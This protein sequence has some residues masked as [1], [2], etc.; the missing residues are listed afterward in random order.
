MEGSSTTFILVGV[1][2]LGFILIVSMIKIVPQRTA[3]IVER[4]GKYK[5]TYTAG[6]QLII[7]FL[8]KVRYRHTL[9]EQ[10][11]D[12]AP[13]ICITRD[14]IAVEV[15]GILYL[16]VLDPQKA[17]Y[18]IDNYRFAS[19]QIAQTTMRSVIGK[20]ELDRTFEE[21]ETINVTI[22]EAVDKA[23]EPW[24]VKVT[25]YEVK[26]IS[27]PQSIKDAM[28]KQMR[29]EREKRAVIAESE[30][31]KQ[32]KI[33]NAEGDKQELIKKSEGE[34]QKRINEAA[35]RASEIEQ[36]AK[37]TASGLRA[38]SSAISEEN[39][40]NAVNLRIAEQYLLAFGN[41]AKTNNTVIIPS[42]LTD[43][44]GII[45][46]ATSVFNETKDKKTK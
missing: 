18:G 38:I 41:I 28:E 2:F 13:Q 17:S 19:I 1:I 4:L 14:N 29:A 27:P 26:N 36:L 3:I 43:I 5:G 21:R 12:V 16:Q 46:T 24:G 45:A 30:G 33:N 23:S 6:F 25:R 39:G 37:A 40:L 20:L 32:A 22:V 42:N 9:K 31:T 15:D 7:P 44:S 8:D 35:G 11:I 34:M 10:A